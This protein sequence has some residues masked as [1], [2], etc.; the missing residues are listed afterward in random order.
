MPEQINSRRVYALDIETTGLLIPRSGISGSDEIIQLA[1]VAEDGSI[2][3]N[4]YFRPEHT[5]IKPYAQ[6][7]NSISYDMIK[8]EPTFSDRL[9]TIQKIIDE[10]GLIVTYNAEFDMAFLTEQGVCASGI[11]V[12]CMMKAFTQLRL[13]RR[14]I[15]KTIRRYSLEQCAQYFGVEITGNTHDALT[16]ARTT[17]ACYREMCKQIGTVAKQVQNYA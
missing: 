7:I 17:L 14:P 1:I 2:L 9:S 12:F 5:H 15:A 16:D 11:P 4:E 13:T 6:R 8:D 10:A 3:F